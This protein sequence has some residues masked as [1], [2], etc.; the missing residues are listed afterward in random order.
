[1]K[2][3]WTFISLLLLFPLIFFLIVEQLNVP[4][5]TD[6][7]YL[8][9]ARSVSVALVAIALLT[10]DIF[11]PVPS[12]LV[13]I[14][15]GAVFGV[16]LGTL[17]SLLGSLGA[18]LIGFLLGRRAGSLLARFVPPEP[19]LQANQLLK[20]WGLLAI[21]VT[22]P[23]PLLAEMTVIVAGTSTIGWKNMALATFAGSLPSAVLYA[24]TGATAAS[25]DNVWLAFGLVL[26]IAGFFWVLS[27]RLHKVITNKLKTSSKRKI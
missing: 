26:L 9:Q 24:L 18:G 17:L 6:P 13:M 12:S 15:N 23:M 16:V 4:I 1:M 25:S 3:Y 10:A 8:M 7:R 11:L 20:K 19:L 2:K 21:I 22:R 14:T 27:E 5:L